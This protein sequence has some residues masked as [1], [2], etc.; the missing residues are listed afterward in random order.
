MRV[1]EEERE[2]ERKREKERIRV[3]EEERRV[4]EQKREELKMMI[5]EIQKELQVKVSGQVMAMLHTFFG[6]VGVLLRHLLKGKQTGELNNETTMGTM[7]AFQALH[8][9]DLGESDIDSDSDS[10]S[11][12]SISSEDDTT[13]G[14]GRGQ[15][16]NTKDPNTC[17]C[18]KTVTQYQRGRKL[19]LYLIN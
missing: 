7:R 4:K 17:Q 9:F 12:Q 15:S 3:E 1:E 14:T 10:D 5:R 19:I 13:K 16:K 11:E 18:G 6:D 8:Q 2:R